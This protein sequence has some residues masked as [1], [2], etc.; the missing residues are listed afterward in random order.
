[1]F[2]SNSLVHDGVGWVCDGKVETAIGRVWLLLQN[3]R[4][5]SRPP[6]DV[7]PDGSSGLD[8]LD[9]LR[10]PLARLEFSFVPH[11]RV[12]DDGEPPCQRHSGFPHGR[13]CANCLGP[14]FEFQWRCGSCQQHVGGFIEQRADPN[15]ATL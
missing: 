5:V 8:I 14:V 3:R 9:F 11:H 4:R 15:I 10:W 7:V 12:H 1:M 2:S 6:S 13:P